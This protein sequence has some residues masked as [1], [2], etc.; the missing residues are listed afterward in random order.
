MES[1]GDTKGTKK[2]SA[3][4]REVDWALFVYLWDKDVPG[5]R[6]TLLILR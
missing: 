5:R 1:D 4:V 3:L 6:W 2:K